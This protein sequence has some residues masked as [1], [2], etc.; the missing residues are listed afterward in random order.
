VACL[1]VIG[2]LLNTSALTIVSKQDAN[3]NREL[4]LHGYVNLAVAAF[5]GPPAHTAISTSLIAIRSGVSWRG[6]GLVA[7]LIA[8]FSLFNVAALMA[9]LPIFIIAGFILYV[10]FDFLYDWL[11]RTQRIYSRG[12]WAVVVIILAIV[13]LIGFAEAIVA[14]LLI[15]SLI[16]AWH[17]AS[18]PV[19][20]RT[21]SL[22]DR[23]S[24]LARPPA[25]AAMLRANGGQVEVI[26]LQG[27]MFFGTADRL[28]EH[29][30]Q[31]I[32]DR[33]RPPLSHLIIDFQH[34]VG[35]DAAAAAQLTRIVT[36]AGQH[37]FKLVF[38]GYP[39]NVLATL[40][41]AA[42]AL[43]DGGGALSLPS[44]D[45]ALEKAEDA[46]LAQSAAN[47]PVPTLLQRLDPFPADL[48]HLERL[49]ATLPQELL[50]KGTVILPIGSAS[51]SLVF[52]EAGRV[53][54]R[55]P[56]AKGDGRRLR[57]MTSGAILG[58]IGLA[59]QSARTA[60]VIAETEVTVRR[61]TL[62]DMQRI[63][64]EEPAL[65]HALHRLQRRSLAE[66]FVYDERLAA[67]TA[68]AVPE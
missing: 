37:P 64:A 28:Y 2:T 40:S 58:D 31:R 7:A 12:E 15:A 43:L 1:T 66:K 51:D 32:S 48:P 10:G 36:V 60:D 62:A 33:A 49:F 61:L 41:R 56:S 38:S 44:L 18:V 63:E 8:L 9:I 3:A 25:E 45:E 4:R 14:G 5:A 39:H 46:V 23:C 42:P 22:Q 47:L 53:A 26:E 59:L 52:L 67:T 19:L 6:A 24:T 30:R 29:I 21:G 35:L 54:I 57:A 11:I 65:S 27:F 55:A 68:S 13:I 34:V 16:F 17:Y 20:R 50:G